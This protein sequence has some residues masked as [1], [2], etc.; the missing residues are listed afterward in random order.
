MTARTI[1]RMQEFNPANEA[2]TAYLERFQLFVEANNIEDDKLVPTLL[3]VVGSDHYSLLRGLISPQLPTRENFWWTGVYP[4]EALRSG[5]YYHRR[6]FPLLIEG[7]KAQVNQSVIIWQI[8]SRCKFGAFLEEALRDRLVCGMQSE[9]TQVLVT[10]ANLTL[11]KALEIS[12]GMEAATI[13]SKELKGS[14]PSNSVLAVETPARQNRP[15][16]RCGRGNHD[17][18]VCK[19]RNTTCHKCGKVGHIAPVCRSK[20]AGRPTRCPTRKT[21]WLATTTEPTPLPERAH[22]RA[23]WTLQN[24]QIRQ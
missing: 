2:V 11:E 8:S 6:T 4:Q 5:A 20:A 7:A 18:S 24:Q 17:K 16:G 14:Q 3:T 23:W 12:Q 22:N 19:F 10:K 21:K 13:K 9:G 1:G 15:C